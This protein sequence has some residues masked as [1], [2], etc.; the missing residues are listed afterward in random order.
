MLRF[1]IRDLLWLMVV[2]GLFVAWSVDHLY[3]SPFETES[4]QLR[5]SLHDAHMHVGAIKSALERDGY[6]I[7]WRDEITNPSDQA[8]I[9]PPPPATTAKP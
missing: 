7:E 5:S 2:V 8:R 9:I 4:Q 3:L 6:K 1:T